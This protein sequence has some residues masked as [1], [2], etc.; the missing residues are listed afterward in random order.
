MSRARCIRISRS[1]DS[2]SRDRGDGHGGRLRRLVHD[3]RVRQRIHYRFSRRGCR[4]RDVSGY[5]DPL[6][7]IRVIEA[8]AMA[9]GSAGWCTMI[10]C[11]SGYI[12]AFLD[13]DVAREMY[14]D[15]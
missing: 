13:E 1:A 2:D 8:M 14:P 11:D 7:Q 5:L 10:G 9:E 12:T 6:T 3:D 15:I 4:A